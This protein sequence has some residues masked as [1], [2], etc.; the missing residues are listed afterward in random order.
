MRRACG[1]VLLE[2]VGA[3]AVLSVGIVGVQQAMREVVL[4]RAQARDFTQARFLLE[5]LISELQVRPQL[6]EGKH[7]GGYGEN[8]PRFRW[9]YVVKRVD[10][11]EAQMQLPQQQQPVQGAAPGVPPPPQ[12]QIPVRF[13]G[14]IKVTISWTLASHKYSRSLETLCQPERLV[15]YNEPQPQ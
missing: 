10:M 12:M 3:L 15:G 14:Q 8:Y 1:Y 4:T 11:P 5:E 9:E 13:M 6:S 7:S 2:A